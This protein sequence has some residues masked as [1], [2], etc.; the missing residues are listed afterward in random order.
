MN[1][2][3]ELNPQQRAVLRE[4][5]VMR[6]RLAKQH[7]RPPFKVLGDKSLMAI[8]QSMPRNKEALGSLHG[9]TRGQMGRYGSKILKTVQKGQR[10]PK[11]RRPRGVPSNDSA[12]AR[13]ESLRKW[14]KA[15]ARN[16]QVESDIIMPRD[17]LWEIARQAPVEK[18]ALRS[19]MNPLLWRYQ[20]Y[21]EE[22]L[23]I[24]K[25]RPQSAK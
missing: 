13:Y 9:M 7:N 23:Q 15:M 20:T 16:R 25:N 10:A 18:R 2:V 24:V 3:H 14:R 8:A 19:I 22:I 21:G 11:P 17:V 6:E 1:G 12:V 5:F 4:L